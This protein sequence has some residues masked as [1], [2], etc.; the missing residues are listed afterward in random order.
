MIVKLIRCKV[1]EESKE[2]FSQAQAEWSALADVE[3]FLGQSGGWDAKDSNLAVIVAWWR[4][5]P[6]YEQFMRVNHGPIFEKSQQA[7]TY[8]S[9]EV[10]GWEAQFDIP[11]EVEN[12]QGAIPDGGLIRLAWCKVNPGRVEHFVEVQKKVWNPTMASAGGMLAGVFSRS[13]QDENQYLVCTLWR[14]ISAHDDYRERHLSKLRDQSEV[15]RDVAH[16]DGYVVH[17]EPSWRVVG[18]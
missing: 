8:Q 1:S 9:C 18:E 5:Q 15:A 4:D 7:D 16:L 6:T 12:V 13:V 10:D 3:G 2:N 11:G 17:V 14:T